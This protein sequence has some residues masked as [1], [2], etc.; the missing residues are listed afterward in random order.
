M[1]RREFLAAVT[2]G[3]L[4]LGDA[5]EAQRVWRVGM[6][7]W[8]GNPATAA[9]LE[10][11][12]PS[13]FRMLQLTDI[14]FFMPH[15]RPGR[16]EKTINDLARLVELARPDLLL[17][18]G[19][20]WQ[21]NPYGRGEEF[22]RFGI[23]Q[24]SALGVPW[25]FTWGNHDK[26]D[27]YKAGHEAFTNGPH[28]LYRGGPGGGNYT[29]HVTDRSG[30]P[31]WDLVC[32]NSNDLGLGQD[33]HAWLDAVAATEA[34]PVAPHAF[35]LFHI[36]LK[37]YDDLWNGG[38]ASGV[39]FESVAFEEEDG[40]TFGLLKDL[41]VVRACFC[42]HDHIND[43]SCCLDGVDLVYG[44]ATGHA[45]YGANRVPKGAKIITVNCET[46]GYGWEAVLADGTRWREARGVQI[47][48]Y[49]DT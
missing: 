28:S 36:P 35:A 5:A 39:R 3:A 46:G 18:T 47:T 44:R 19:D 45:A 25:L 41:E 2:T 8:D 4:A 9:I 17:V 14:H 21:D 16:D 37:Q 27:D 33:Q 29:V 38:C 11:E 34:A 7:R 6:E 42:G 48:R 20:L 23:E 24:I 43:F 10:I 12:N 13:D 32:L 22:M 40:S 26:L 49:E 1:N 31:V 15:P 30:A